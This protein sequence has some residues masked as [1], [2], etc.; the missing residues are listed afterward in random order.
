MVEVMTAEFVCRECAAE[1]ETERSLHAHFKAHDFK[2]VDYYNK[3]YPRRDRFDGEFIRFKNKEYYLE[4]EFNS[5]ENLKNCL[6][7][8]PLETAKEYCRE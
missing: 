7:Q 5:K 3:F 2:L 8:Q 4:T 1:F 6:N